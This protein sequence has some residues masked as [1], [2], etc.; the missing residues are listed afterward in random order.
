MPQEWIEALKQAAE[1]HLT[2]IHPEIRKEYMQADTWQQITER[3]MALQEGDKER[4]VK[5]P[6][7]IEK[8]VAENE[9][10]VKL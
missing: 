2:Q 5:T 10:A 4:K 9:K 1:K 8:K 7:K 3:D 6:Q